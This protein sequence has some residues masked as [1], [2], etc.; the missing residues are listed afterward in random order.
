MAIK[1]LL[2]HRFANSSIT[3]LVMIIYLNVHLSIV[4]AQCGSQSLEKQDRQSKLAMYKVTLKTYW[5]R[6]RFPKHYPEW[7][8]PAQ[9]GKLV[10]KL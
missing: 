4:E 10:G 7:R 1:C 9:F 2:W 3:L 5:S 8:P 6:T